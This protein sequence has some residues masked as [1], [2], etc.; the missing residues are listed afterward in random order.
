MGT[1]FQ[2]LHRTSGRPFAGWLT[3][4]VDISIV[5][6]APDLLGV[7]V[8][9]FLPA[10]WIVLHEVIDPTDESVQPVSWYFVIVMFKVVKPGDT[11]VRLTP[12][13]NDGTTQNA[14][15]FGVEAQQPASRG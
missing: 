5:V 6:N 1:H 14:F 10:I 7:Q 2:L 12:I 8:G 15:K 9:D 11:S 13:L 4:F 3:N